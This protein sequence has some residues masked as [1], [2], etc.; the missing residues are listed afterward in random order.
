MK[1]KFAK[2]LLSWMMAAALVISML[3]FSAM[4][5][6]PN[7]WEVNETD[8]T[9]SIY[10]AT[11]LREWADS[12]TATNNTYDGYTISIEN[13]IDLSGKNWEPIINLGGTVIID[14]KNHTI[15]NMTI[16][17]SYNADYGGTITALGFI[18]TTTH[19]S[20][21]T[22]KDLAFE[23]AHVS[24]PDG[25]ETRSLTYCGVVVGHGPGSLYSDGANGKFTFNNV[26]VRNSVVTGGFNN[27]AIL[28]Y[29]N[30]IGHGE[31]NATADFE[32]TITF[33]GCTVENTFVGG[34]NSTSGSLFGMG[35]TSVAVK[36]CSTKGVRLYSDGL[37]Y[38][39]VEQSKGH[40][41]VGSIYDQRGYNTEATY[42]NCTEEDSYIVYPVLYHYTDSTVQEYVEVNNPDALAV[43][44]TWYNDAN[45]TTEVKE[46]LA[47]MEGTDM[48]PSSQSTSIKNTQTYDTQDT[49][50]VANPLTH[51]AIELYTNEKNPGKTSY[52]GLDKKIVAG[53]KEVTEDD[54]A[55]GDE[56][57]F[58]LTS[59]VPDDLLNYLNPK[60]VYPP[61]VGDDEPGNPEPGTPADSNR[62]HYAL[63]F[64]DQMD[65]GLS[66]VEPTDFKVILDR[67]EGQTDTVIPLKDAVNEG[68]VLVTE[69]TDGCDFEITLDLV[70]LYED[71]IITDDDIT[72]ATP[73]VITYTGQL[74]ESVTNGTF[75]NTAWVSYPSDESQPV[76]VDVNTYQIKIFKYD[77]NKGIDGEGTALPGAEFTLYSDKAATTPVEGVSPV[78]TGDDGFA[79]FDGLDAGTYYLKETKAPEGYVCS[80]EVVTIEIPDDA[81]ADKI[82]NVSFANSLIPHTGGMGTTL[83]SIVGGALIA[84]AGVVFVISRRRKARA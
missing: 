15:S 83:F 33:D 79:T 26:S 43:D 28:G 10:T 8:K 51:G 72:N 54:V 77:Q 2:R 52:P 57:N 20:E 30:G 74:D 59:N 84:T 23:N 16:Q 29:A 53:D 31:S 7:D 13:D 46:I 41:F 66:L 24:T 35:I 81:D 36:N 4:A 76:S 11:G 49:E 73:I 63:T 12:A 3:P 25:D 45:Y 44:T 21:L 5:A 17:D 65:D 14:G 47:N 34:Y 22:V 78:L 68:Y 48:Y 18:G 82:V 32:T 61:V 75:H 19:Y 69:T 39:P 42:E 6:Q 37:R 9:V 80:N 56:I 67:P 58:K 60:D 50:K 38:G 55:A 64:H 27:G 40:L 71:G 70:A 62:G 1:K